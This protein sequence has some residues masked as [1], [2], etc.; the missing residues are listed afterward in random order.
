M[1]AGESPEG[2]V[3]KQAQVPFSGFRGQREAASI[4]MAEK[5]SEC[6]SLRL[7]ETPT[8]KGLEELLNTGRPSCNHADEVWPN[9]FLGDLVI[10]HNRFGLWK[11]GI[12]HVLNAAH[13]M[14]FCK[15]SHGFYGPGIE[16][17]G[18]PAYDLPSFDLSPYFYPAAEFIQKAL[19]IPGAKILVHC[20]VGI[21]RS[22][23]LVL[24]FLMIYHHLSL[25]EA[26]KAVK[27][28]R[29]IFPNRGFQKQLRNL[30]MQL[31]PR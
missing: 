23:S 7:A 12:S 24:A 19:S 2:T 4:A 15:G 22:S 27:K 17:Y 28:H 11:M 20:A 9:L 26:I 18:V 30:D 10:A 21:S 1:A 8:L 14:I 31:K 16:Y 13:G 3:N 29:W 6:S 25:T 5:D